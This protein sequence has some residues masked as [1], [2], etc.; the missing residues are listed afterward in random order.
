MS[1]DVFFSLV[2]NVIINLSQFVYPI[3]TLFQ[4]KTGGVLLGAFPLI[5]IVVE[6]DSDGNVLRAL[7]SAR[8]N[9][10]TEVNDQEEGLYL[11]S[12]ADSGIAFVPR[13]SL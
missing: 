7:D 2:F 12:Y 10:I 3:S 4:V 11:G 5:G 13:A 1:P 6:L 9:R 8:H